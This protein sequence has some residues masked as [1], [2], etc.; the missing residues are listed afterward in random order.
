VT[1][2]RLE[3]G[4]VIAGDVSIGAIERDDDGVFCFW[5]CETTWGGSWSH[6]QMR[7]IADRLWELNGGNY[8]KEN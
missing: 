2:L 4:F 6:A 1:A 8:G 3:H 7:W 5:P